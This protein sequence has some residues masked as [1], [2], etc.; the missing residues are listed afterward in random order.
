MSAVRLLSLLHG[1]RQ[2]GNGWRADCPN[3]HSKSRG[4][5]SI[6]EADD[7]RV[8]LHCFACHD[9][10]GILH[11]L[12]LEMADLFPERIKDPSP[13]ARKAAA[14]A[15]RRNA[16]G[17]ALGVLAREATVVQ[18]AADDMHAGKT[19]VAH[20]VARVGLAARR[21]AQTGEVLHERP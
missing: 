14:E 12:G 20:D 16:W 17:A 6:T 13:E 11:A 9:T 10:L 21:I 1:V 18:I 15:F 19:L 7:G 4:S 3:G 2:Y 8:M 5:L